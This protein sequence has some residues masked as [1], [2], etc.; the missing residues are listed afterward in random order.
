MKTI[1]GEVHP[2]LMG[3]HI[4]EFL[5]LLDGFDTD[6]TEQAAAYQPF[7]AQRA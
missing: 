2:D 4:G 3:C 6:L 5:Q 1:V 7:R